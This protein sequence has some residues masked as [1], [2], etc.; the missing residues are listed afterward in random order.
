M[1]ASAR[2]LWLTA[3]LAAL[4]APAEAH[5][6]WVSV[7]SGSG[8][9]PEA[10]VWFSEEPSPGAP[11]LVSKI[12]HTQLRRVDGAETSAVEL[13]PVT[14]DGAGELV[15]SLPSAENSIRLEAVC[16]YGTFSRGGPPILLQ[17]Y[18]KAL[19]PRTS[20]HLAAIARSE[21]LPLD[22]VP[23][24]TADGL[25]FTVLWQ[26]KPAGQAEVVV[27]DLEGEDE[28]LTTDDQG[29]ALHRNPGRGLIAARVGRVEED[30]SGERSGKRYQSVRHYATVTL[31]LPAD[32]KAA[33]APEPAAAPA[34]ADAQPAGELL[35]QAR[36]AR[37]VWS[38]FP[39]FAADVTL[40]ADGETSEGRL[41]VDEAGEVVLDL[42]S[43]EGL[44]WARRQLGSLVSHR[45]PDG[46]IGSGASYVTESGQ[47]PLGR[48]I[49]LEGES[50]GSVYRIR[51]NVV[52]EVNRDTA[53]GRFTI[54]VLDVLWNAE[55]K[56]LPTAFNVSSW[57]APSGR[58][59]S[60]HTVLQRWQRVGAFDLPAT[61]LEVES[62]EGTRHV[63]QLDFRNHRL[64]DPAAAR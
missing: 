62:T 33:A 7:E 24:L 59:K 15:G 60:S 13:S 28:T 36:A 30:R 14:A 3:A 20:A 58:L 57:E 27:L 6:V 39:G 25:R 2:S 19:R 4:A 8:G 29:H 38:E 49:R 11:H 47:H 35:A 52:T 40:S 26:G 48:L 51:D 46:E 55:H 12:A 22:V 53:G 56:Y 45:M 34:A 37:A 63:R 23:E 21:N 54:S 18:A 61:V 1:I 17:Y 16:D 64:L 41:T 5:F 32:A 44:K 31:R 9:R 42:P 50:M 10:R 43:S